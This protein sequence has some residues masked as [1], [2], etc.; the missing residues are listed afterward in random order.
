MSR[1][2][3]A[4]A[5]VIATLAFAAHQ[6]S[7][8]P[9]ADTLAAV[10]A[11]G[12][13][14][15]G[16]TPSTVGFAQPDSSGVWRGIDVD[17]CRAIAAAVL[18]DANRTRFVTP[19]TANRFAMLQSGEIDVLLRTTTWTLS[20]EATLGV[21]FAGVNMYDGQGFMVKRATNISA[22]RQLDGTTICVLPGTTTETITA[23]YFRTHTMRYTPLPVATIEDLRAAFLA[24]RCNVFTLDVSALA[25]FRA[26]QGANAES[27]V[28]LP[29]I[30]SKEPLGPVVRQGDWRWFN[31]VRW[32]HN[33]MV[34]AEE[35]GISSGNIDSVAG[36]TNPDIQR[37]MGRIGDLGQGL[38]LTNDW[39][40]RIVS[41]VGNYG[42]VWERNITPIGIER[43]INNL[44]NR[45][46]LHYAPPMR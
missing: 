38:G 46:G 7:A 3:L 25:A 15:C 33:A 13:V 36:S 29:E 37:F 26:S 39:A 23:D 18:G 10:R 9:T 1:A 41:Q 20:R 27:F 12:V 5:G 21:A 43:G 17:Y 4:S 16:V 32:T 22:V 19:T 6:A 34:A 2:L 24:D 44:W 14:T 30:I 45:G 35:L 42:E 28:V 40:A 11:R 8:Q 31:A